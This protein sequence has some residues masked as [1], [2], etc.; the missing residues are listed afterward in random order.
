MA[1]STELGWRIVIVRFFFSLFLL[2][3]FNTFCPHSFSELYGPMLMELYHNVD[4]HMK[5]CTWLWNGQDGCRF[6]GNC[7]NPKIVK[8]FQTGRNSTG[9]VTGMRWFAVWLWNFQNGCRYH[10]NS[11]NIKNSNSFIITSSWMKLYE[12][13]TQYA[14]MSKQYLDSSKWPPLSWKLGPSFAL[15]L[16]KNA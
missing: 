3:F 4:Q 8:V 1:P 7:K 9:M 11:S 2:F 12:N 10:G 14:K 15:T 16:W 6:H 5:L 13:V